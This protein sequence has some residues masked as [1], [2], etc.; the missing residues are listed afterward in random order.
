MSDW[1]PI[2]TAPV[3][4]FDEAEWFMDASPSYI[5][6]D[7]WVQLARYSYTKR[8]KGRWRD[9]TG[10]IVNPTHW[11]PTPPNPEAKP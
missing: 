7:K 1:Q 3:S 10:R 9:N 11:M 5:V 6:F 2:D 4:P 8:G